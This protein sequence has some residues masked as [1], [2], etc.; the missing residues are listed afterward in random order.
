MNIKRRT[1]SSRNWLSRNFRDPYIKER[2]SKNL[3]ARSWFKIKEIDDKYNIFQIGMNVIDLGSSPGGWSEYLQ[4]K[5]G[6]SGHILACDLLPMRP[7]K[8]VI[9]L[10]GDIADSVILKKI[11]SISKQYHWNAIVSD[12]SP[13]ISGCSIIDNSKAFDLSDS[14]IYIA[15]RFLSRKGYFIIK[16]FQGG[17]F[18]QYIKKIYNIFVKVKIF[19]PNSSRAGSREVFIIAHGRKI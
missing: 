3:R 9:F 4:K 17:D 16:L 14:A 18:N 5:I 19:K 2:N 11:V 12:M 13:N 8:R 6:F 15:D 7:L 1:N 10:K